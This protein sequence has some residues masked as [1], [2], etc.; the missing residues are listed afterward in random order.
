MSN[1]KTTGTPRLEI[2]CASEDGHA[3]IYN[4]EE[5]RKIEL[6]IQDWERHFPTEYQLFL[7]DLN[8]TDSSNL[9]TV[10]KFRNKLQHSVDE[11]RLAEWMIEGLRILREIHLLFIQLED[12]LLDSGIIGIK[13]CWVFP[14]IKDPEEDGWMRRNVLPEQGRYM[15]LNDYVDSD[16][17]PVEKTWFYELVTGWFPEAADW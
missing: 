9:K 10:R 17:V 3:L 5:Y 4:L 1:D 2:R 6:R 7:S 13:T 14:D 11:K 16:V 8:E 12:E 15:S